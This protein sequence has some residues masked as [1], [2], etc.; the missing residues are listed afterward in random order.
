VLSERG[1]VS[2]VVYGVDG[3]P[4]FSLALSTVRRRLG[5]PEHGSAT[6]NRLGDPAVLKQTLE[7]AGFS[8]LEVHAMTCSIHM[9]SAA[10]CVRYL[11]DTSPTLRETLSSSTPDERKEA[12]NEIERAL[13]RY[14]G[15]AGFEVDHRILIAAGT[16]V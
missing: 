9:A 13:S 1:R 2:L 12:W 7:R 8:D 15:P 11:Q 14:Q 16:R 6:A 3:S 4:E 5:L 10:E